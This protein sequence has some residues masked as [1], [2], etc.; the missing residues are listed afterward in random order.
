M[1][2]EKINSTTPGKVNRWQYAD[3]KCSGG[4]T[5]KDVILDHI[6]LLQF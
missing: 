4:V 2:G 6:K 3:A 5:L 1:R